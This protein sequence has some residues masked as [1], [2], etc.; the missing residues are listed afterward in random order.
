MLIRKTPV[1]I[2]RVP[3]TLEPM[4]KPIS[5]TIAFHII[6][7]LLVFC[8]TTRQTLNAA[9]SKSAL[10][11]S[12]RSLAEDLF[13]R[14]DALNRTLHTR[15]LEERTISDYLQLLDSYNQVIRL[16]TDNFYSAESLAK[17]AE[18]MREMA[19]TSGDSALY[20]QA[21]ETLRQLVSDHPH[22]AF[23]GDALITI[24]QI[25][26]E[27]LQDLDGAVAAYK[28]LIAYFPASVMAREARAV[29]SR[30]E[31]ELR[32][33]SIDVT[34]A[35]AGNLIA[36][37]TK[38]T[39]IRNFTGSDYARIVI[40][41]SGDAQFAATRADDNRIAITFSGAAIAPSLYGRRFILGDESLLKRITVQQG[42]ASSGVQV[43]LQLAKT[44]EFSTFKL[45]SPERLIVDIHTANA[46]AKRE[47]AVP[48]PETLETVETVETVVKEQ[49]STASVS[50][51]ASVATPANPVEVR[52]PADAM[53]VNPNPVA[54]K[55]E[56]SEMVAKA[57]KPA[58]KGQP[59][60]TLPEI[61]EPIV[62]H[63]PDAQNQANAIAA[64][65]EAKVQAGTSVKC[66]V[67]D[68]GHG[69][70]DTGT[71]GG[72]GLLEKDLTLD[73]ARRLRNYIKRNYPDIEVVM[74][75]DSDT[76]IALE[77]RT[78]IANARH[79]DLFIS[80]HANSS[81]SRS[82]AGVETF[83]AKEDKPAAE[84]EK[85]AT[86]KTAKP[87][88]ATPTEAAKPITASVTIGN[89]VAESRELARYIQSGLVRG[90]GATSPNSAANRGVKHAGFVVLMGAAMP[91]VLA[92]VSFVSNPK[93]EALLMTG[94]YR[95]RIAASLF[96][97]L[98]AYL[99]KNRPAEAKAK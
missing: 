16:N 29:V 59:L 49:P 91:S 32:H 80:V 38:L 95:E 24:A 15:P 21:I 37:I 17:R 70:H 46:A 85:P 72:N 92:E 27:N 54:P 40:D 96:A 75:R 83:F 68:A 26:E 12:S 53:T 5:R 67:I 34:A 66:V 45:S 44:A 7:S 78:A 3:Q 51:T 50:A 1:E 6:I 20:Q 36:G 81:P 4:Q 84:T 8:M 33:R 2:Y 74:T 25:Y 65:V 43:D 98:N 39:N 79:A 9:Y 57:N 82:A 62:V 55:L 90:I 23:V 28:E 86:E 35:N 63:N 48:T 94:Q 87:A 56:R 10:T 11:T 18:L 73:V 58:I 31:A 42:E 30:F 60:M 41:L 14:A 69:G 88:A 61:T 99:K 22:S 97:G 93:D 52:K 19:D 77:Q 13:R 89:R 47:A 76:F 64:T 71:I